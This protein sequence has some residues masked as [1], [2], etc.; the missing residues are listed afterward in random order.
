MP[1]TVPAKVESEPFSP[2]G[3]KDAVEG[4]LDLLPRSKKLDGLGC[5][6]EIFVVVDRLAAKA[7]IP[8]NQRH[9]EL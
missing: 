4:L 5:A 9:K 2:Q 6:N 1:A 7:G 8:V 3:A